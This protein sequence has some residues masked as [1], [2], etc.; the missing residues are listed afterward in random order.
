MTKPLSSPL[1]F[2]ANGVILVRLRKQL[3]ALIY[4]RFVLPINIFL[5]FYHYC[6]IFPLKRDCHNQLIE[7]ADLQI[8]DPSLRD[9]S[10]L[11]FHWGCVRFCTESFAPQMSSLQCNIFSVQKEQK[12]LKIL[13]LVADVITIVWSLNTGGKTQQKVN[14]RLNYS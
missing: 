10:P 12:G 7:L 2:W 11:Q 9:C 8:I 1:Q 3:I 6:F 4:G 14:F 5:H 13:C